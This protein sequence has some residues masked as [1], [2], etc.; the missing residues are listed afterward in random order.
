M[1]LILYVILILDFNLLH[2]LISLISLIIAF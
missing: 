2:S 1:A